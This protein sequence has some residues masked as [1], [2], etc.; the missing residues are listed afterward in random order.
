MV[1]NSDYNLSKFS[2]FHSSNKYFLGVYHVSRTVL[3]AEDKEMNKNRQNY[4]TF[5][6]AFILVGW[7]V[8]ILHVNSIHTNIQYTSNM[9][10]IKYEGNYHLLN[11]C[12]LSN[13]MLSPFCVINPQMLLSSPFFR[14]GRGHSN[15]LR[16]APSLNLGRPGIESVKSEPLL[17]GEREEDATPQSCGIPSE[18]LF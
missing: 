2:K 9:P 8:M 5:T 12:H 15:F 14:K 3:V 13:I 11:V 4:L 6:V 18:S 10:T 1:S 17:K 16:P 7:I